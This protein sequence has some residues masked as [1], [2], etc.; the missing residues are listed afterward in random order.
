MSGG[1]RLFTIGFC[2]L[3]A[4]CGGKQQETRLAENQVESLAKPLITFVELGSVNCIP[5][6]LMVPV[7][8]AVEHKYGDQLQVIFHDVIKQPEY[9]RQYGI[10]LIPTQ[11]FLDR[12]GAELFRHEGFFAE[13]SI[14]VF[15]QK[16]GLVAK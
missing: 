4:A 11:V 12:N 13:D 14:D 6:K 16:Q 10:R 2:L 5:C 15:L 9:G 3:I 8:E 7:M 1:K